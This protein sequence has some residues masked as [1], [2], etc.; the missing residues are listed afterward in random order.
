MEADA[1]RTG[2]WG[3]DQLSAVPSWMAV[4]LRF[5]GD[6]LQRNSEAG[7][8][9][10]C[11]NR[12][13][14]SP[15]LGPY[16]WVFKGTVYSRGLR[17]TQLPAK[18]KRLVAGFLLLHKLG[19][20]KP[21]NQASVSTS[22][23]G[24]YQ[25]CPVTL[26]SQHSEHTPTPGPWL[27][28]LPLPGTWDVDCCCLSP[29]AQLSSSQEASGNVTL[30]AESQMSHSRR[31]PC[32]R[33]TSGIEQGTGENVLEEIAQYYRQSFKHPHL[34]HAIFKGLCCPS[35][36]ISTSCVIYQ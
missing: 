10:R 1:G 9:T 14:Q 18:K 4:R 13:P 29:Q 27:A 6:G 17:W 22:R 32:L 12:R 25:L 15:S 30:K 3:Q 16:C 24:G 19:N 33:T 11:A 21:A 5:R 23:S 2:H 20:V 36:I 8:A 34:R 28:P 26:P 31:S 35:P 7:G